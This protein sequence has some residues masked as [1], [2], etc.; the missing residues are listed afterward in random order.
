MG[1]LGA[2]KIQ[3][4]SIVDIA[5]MQSLNRAG[6]IRECVKN[7]GMIIVDECHHVPAFTFEQIIRK[8]TARYVYGLTATPIRQDGHQPIMFLYCGPVR[9]QVDAKEQAAN[10]PF[11]HYIIP[12]FTPFRL[13]LPDH[14]DKP[15][16]QEIYSELTND[17]LRNQLIVDDIVDCHEK[18]RNILVLTGRV[19]HVEELTNRLKP[20]IPDLISLTGG[21]GSKHTEKELKRISK[22]PINKPITL[23]STGKFIGEG[24][25]EPRLDTLFMAM[26]IAWKGTVHQYA[27]RLHRLWENKNEVTIYDYVDVHVPVLE[28]MYGKRLK[29]YASIGYR[30]KVENIVDS[31]KDIIFDNHSFL[32]VYLRDMAHALKNIFIVTPFVTARRVVQ[33]MDCFAPLLA[34]QL[35]ITI[36]T[37]P[38]C[39]FPH[40]QQEQ[41]TLIFNQLTDAGIMLVFKPHIHQKFAIIDQKIVWYGSINLLGF[42]KSQESIMRLISTN[43]AQ[44]LSRTIQP[45]QT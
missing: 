41:L 27:G 6:Y 36:L 9:F 35:P 31:P 13:P 10:R 33:M 7:Y 23:I 5:I 2:G 34:K 32:P 38:A 26:P 21:M 43:I 37:R 17:E 3:L 29:G 11:E 22:T 4:S 16:I 30:A 25:D 14:R 19:A 8:S 45:R 20:K 18:S 12:R 15:S 39:T 40:L 44:E 24:F 1:Q 28:K 42:G